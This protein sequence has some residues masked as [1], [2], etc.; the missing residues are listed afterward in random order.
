MESSFE[1]NG[2]ENFEPSIKGSLKATINGVEVPIIDLQ[3][4]SRRSGSFSFGLWERHQLLEQVFKVRPSQTKR[5]A[6]GTTE[7]IHFGYSDEIPAFDLRVDW[8]DGWTE[9]R[10]IRLTQECSGVPAIISFV[11]DQRIEG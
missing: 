3:W 5:K 1:N 9:V 11:C 4:H 10:G 6:G 8:A 2:G 7:I